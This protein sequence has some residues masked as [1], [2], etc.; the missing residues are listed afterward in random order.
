M[1]DRQSLHHKWVM[2]PLEASHVELVQLVAE[3]SRHG[4]RINR[5]IFRINAGVFERK[6]K[7]TC[8]SNLGS[9]A[10]FCLH[11]YCVVCQVFACEEEVL[12][13]VECEYSVSGVRIKGYSFGACWINYGVGV[14]NAAPC[15][16]NCEL[17]NLVRAGDVGNRVD[18]V[19]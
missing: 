4:Y 8:L 5:E 7:V 13:I 18:L 15:R 6:V 12:Q 1:H 11:C 16:V 14:G 2:T 19:F 9:V 17:G 10:R 3:S